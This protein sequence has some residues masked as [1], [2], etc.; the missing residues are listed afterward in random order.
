[1]SGEKT[2]QP[3]HKRLRDSRRK[4]EVAY[5]RDFTQALLVIALLGYMVA[6]AQ[7][8]VEGM[9]RL[10]LAPTAMTGLEFGAALEAMLGVALREGMDLLMPFILIVLLVGL[11]GD[12]LQVG[13]VL[14]FEKLKPSAKKL[15]VISNLKNVFSKKNLVEF[16]KSVIKII[17]LVVLVSVILRDAM[18]EL[19]RI[20]HSGLQGAAAAFA[21]ML[22]VL[23]I[24]LSIAYVVI[25]LADLVWQRLQHT[26]QQMMSK[27]EVKQEYKEMEGDPHIKH[28]RKHLHQE[29][30]MQNAVGRTRKASVV[31][32]N[33]THVAV[34]L[35]YDEDGTPLPV[36]VAK[37]EGALA[38]E[39]IKAAREAGVPVMQNIPLAHALLERGQVDQYIPGELVEPVAELLRLLR[40]MV[41]APHPG[42]DS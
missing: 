24:N 29:M 32:V 7:G 26:R 16:L 23:V 36:V 10:I 14:A 9:G 31:V 40:Q 22:R 30:A 20:P 25:A 37:G 17:V 2:E 34:A 3:T 15:N 42:D 11:F 4:G 1:M 13:I 12:L 28:Q 21:G 18:P 35:Y 6:N 38:Y 39:M 19:V 8:I 5:S 41:E 27:E 33:P